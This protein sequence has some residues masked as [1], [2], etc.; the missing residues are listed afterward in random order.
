MFTEQ[1]KWWRVRRE[2]ADWLWWKA[3][4]LLGDSDEIP[5]EAFWEATETVMVGLCRGAGHEVEDDMCGKPEH[6][7]C[8]YCRQSMAGRERGANAPE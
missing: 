5:D 7:Y 4:D 6:R 8:L 1:E 2:Y 3:D